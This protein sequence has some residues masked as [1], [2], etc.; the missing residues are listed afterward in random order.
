[1]RLTKSQSEH[2]HTGSMQYIVVD[3]VIVIFMLRFCTGEN[4][5]L[6]F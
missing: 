5:T 3:V 4:K 1:M 6:S 2:T